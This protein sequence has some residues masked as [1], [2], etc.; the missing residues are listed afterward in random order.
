MARRTAQFPQGRI[1]R[2]SPVPYYFQLASILQGEITS[3]RWL[4][5]DQIPSEPAFTR[6]F[7]VSRSTVRQAFLT[8][9]NLGM[10][11]REKG[12]GTFVAEDRPGSWLLQSPRGFFREEVEQLGRK[13][14]STVMRK[15][16][17]ELPA[18]AIHALGL[19]PG[20]IGVTVERLRYVDDDV[21][22]YV[23]NHLPEVFADKVLALEGSDSLYGLIETAFDRIVARAHRQVKAVNA[24]RRLA[25]LLGV[26][27]HTALAFIESVSWDQQEVPIDCFRAWLRTDR[28]QIDIDVPRDLVHVTP[29]AASR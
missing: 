1:E 23:V 8:L 11:R 24:G 3:G 12:R 25:R 29:A 2:T 10:I 17:E 27:D 16:R 5:G 26:E 14:T 19:A 28:L 20:S 21:A 13:V 18:W 6:S 7:K 22:L 4:P 9:E 15:E